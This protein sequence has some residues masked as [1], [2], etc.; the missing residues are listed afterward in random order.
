MEVEIFFRHDVPDGVSVSQV[1]SWASFMLGET[2]SI[3]ES[4]PMYQAYPDVQAKYMTVEVEH[5][6]D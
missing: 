4:N 1:E 6:G 2:A 3:D 5:L